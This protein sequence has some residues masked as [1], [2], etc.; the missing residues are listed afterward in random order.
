MQFLFRDQSDFSQVPT[1]HECLERD[2]LQEGSFN[3][4]ASSRSHCS[5]FIEI[6]QMI[7]FLDLALNSYINLILF[8]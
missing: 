2:R 6:I 5:R 3:M 7:I 1:C 4:A 8:E